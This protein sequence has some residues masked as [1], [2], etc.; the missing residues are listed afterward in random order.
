MDNINAVLKTVASSLM[1]FRN[2]KGVANRIKGAKAKIMP[3][4]MAL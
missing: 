3:I 2:K 4:S 1:C